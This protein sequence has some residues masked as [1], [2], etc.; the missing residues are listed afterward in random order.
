MSV[1][2][3]NL[4]FVLSRESTGICPTQPTGVSDIGLADIHP[5]LGTEPIRTTR[6][7]HT[8]FWRQGSFS[9]SRGCCVFNQWA[10]KESYKNSHPT[11]VPNMSFADSL[12]TIC[13]IWSVQSSRE[14]WVYTT[15][16]GLKCSSA[17]FF[18]YNLVSFIV[19]SETWAWNVEKNSA[20]VESLYKTG[21]VN[22]LSVL[23]L[24]SDRKTPAHHQG[25]EKCYLS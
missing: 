25:R 14:V 3:I 5:S 23:T 4:S 15:V 20:V 7:T 1:T 16:C 22:F 8:H 6:A 19:K 21:V 10:R 13:Q 9:A 18:K 2:F 12:V 24:L 11:S 17:F